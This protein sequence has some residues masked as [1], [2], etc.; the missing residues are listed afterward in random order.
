M[1]SNTVF[2][3]LPAGSCLRLV[4]LPQLPQIPQRCFV[5]AFL[6][7]PCGASDAAVSG[8]PIDLVAINVE[9]LAPCTPVPITFAAG[10]PVGQRLQLESCLNPNT[11]S[12]TNNNSSL[13]VP[14]GC[15]GCYN[16]AFSA[17]FLLSVIFTDIDNILI[18]NGLCVTRNGVT[19]VLEQT[20][21]TVFTF[22]ES[23]SSKSIVRLLPGDIISACI[24][25]R[26]DTPGTIT[27]AIFNFQYISIVLEQL[28]S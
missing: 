14:V 15:G 11:W 4:P 25:F 27:E 28:S 12:L 21:T 5:N 10:A 18:D 7:V 8:V 6:R 17:S 3:V 22:S 16:V 24:R 1:I 26:S 2:G 9:P 19:Q 20:V 23:F 13:V